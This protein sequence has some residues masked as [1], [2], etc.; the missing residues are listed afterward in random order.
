MCL[1]YFDISLCQVQCDSWDPKEPLCER[2]ALRADLGQPKPRCSPA[3]ENLLW[4]IPQLSGGNLDE[5]A[6]EVRRQES[7][8]YSV[9]GA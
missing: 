2:K 8:L 1:M 4:R 7:M 3:P 9:S 5:A 6:V